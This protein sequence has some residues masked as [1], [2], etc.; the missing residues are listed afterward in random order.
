MSDYFLNKIYDS[1]LVNKAPKTKSTF[2]TLS[3]SYGLVYEQEAEASSR[4]V[5]EPKP[6]K[7]QQ[8]LPTNKPQLEQ[9]NSETFDKSNL[10]SDFNINKAIVQR[11]P[12]TPLQLRL[13]PVKKTGTGAGELSIANLISNITDENILDR[14]VLGQGEPFDVVWP[15]L[16]KGISK[17]NLG[18]KFEVKELENPN[19][20]LKSIK[21][22]DTVS[23]GVEGRDFATNVLTE[24]ERRVVEILNEL[25]DL[26]DDEQKVISAQIVKKTQPQ[27]KKPN[28]ITKAGTRR[29]LTTKE[30]QQELASY[31]KA[32]TAFKNWSLKE[33]LEVIQESTKKGELPLTVILGRKWDRT[34]AEPKLR[35]FSKDP[36]KNRLF[37][38]SLRRLFTTINQLKQEATTGLQAQTKTAEPRIGSLKDVF[39][40][41]Y[42]PNETEASADTVE[43]VADYLDKRA[44][45]VDKELS[46]LKAKNT[47][48]KFTVNDFYSSINVVEMLNWL[49][50]IEEK[51]YIPATILNF[52]PKDLTG[53]FS[54]SSR[55]YIYIPRNE[56]PNY[57]TLDTFSR[58]G[59]KIRFKR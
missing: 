55:G 12:W 53:F 4:E 59:A 5:E 57:I 9:S 35:D 49:D 54:A 37:Y 32:F 18:F 48:Y 1:L 28:E 3:E 42:K 33:Y 56:I 20:K 51:I 46:K 36:G 34:E 30:Y 15:P 40:K 26:S 52:F 2:R 6:S 24:V 16:G 39:Y 22:K 25:Q 17:Y 38:I 29:D 58:G 45:T 11:T 19:E 41:N 10:P 23:I 43:K 21:L 44:V 14:M 13:F 8:P 31:E 47:N 7:Q 27:L 50:Q